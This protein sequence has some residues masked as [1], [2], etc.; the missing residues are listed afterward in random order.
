MGAYEVAAIVVAVAVA[1]CVAYLIPIL[2]Q[3][4]RTLEASAQLLAKTNQDIPSLIKEMR[5]MTETVSRV[6]ERAEDG[7]EHATGFLHAVGEIGDT[8][9]QVHATVRGGG[10]TLLVNLAS[11][12]AGFKAAST[13][14]K[15]RNNFRNTREDSN[16]G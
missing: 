13:V 4:R 15:E 8:V 2:I 3:L 6:A 7:V 9:R 5:G 11:V 1:V 12:M 14:I 10:G 16:G